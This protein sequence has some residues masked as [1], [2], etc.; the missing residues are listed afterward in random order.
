MTRSILFSWPKTKSVINK[1]TNTLNLMKKTIAIVAAAA[2]A[3]GLTSCDDSV[4]SSSSARKAIKKE[5]IFAENYATAQFNTGYYE[6]GE[7][8]L[9]NL[10]RLKA[11]GMVTYTA[12]T[13]IE[14]VRK[15][16]YSYWS[17][18]S[19]YNVDEEH[20]FVTVQLTEEGKKHLVETPVTQR[21][22]IAKDFKANEDY[23]EFIPD[24]MKI[25]STDIVTPVT[26][27]EVV[28]AVED[29]VPDSAVIEEVTATEEVTETQA[30]SPAPV[31]AEPNAA[32]EAA[33]A[34]VNIETH[35][36]LLGRFS[37]EKVREV[38]CSEEMAK[39][40]VGSCTAIITF[41]DKTP[42]GYVL[43]APKQDFLKGV[44]VSLV[45]YEDLGWT[46]SS[47]DD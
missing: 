35:N 20:T 5:A 4:L 9:L 39:N 44:K 18:Y 46:V 25:E 2:V 28:E 12:E 31:K 40:G 17:G 30:P 22:D 26:E 36:V 37:L 10:A 42:F 11:A 15:S 7:G 21:A 45:Y 13:I 27:K 16:T 24:Y 19:Y 6:A 41:K 43:G 3:I 47:F 38:R 34:K 23:E 8:D 33:M 14:K 1:P 32:Y 29:I